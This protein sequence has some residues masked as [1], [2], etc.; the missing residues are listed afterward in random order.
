MVQQ[1]FY[2]FERKII[3]WLELCTNLRMK[4]SENYEGNVPIFIHFYKLTK[5]FMKR[6]FAQHFVDC[7][8]KIN[9]NYN[10]TSLV[11]FL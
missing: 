8:D 5:V 1:G 4:F 3:I 11:E 6:N 2:I 10:V 7:I 9:S